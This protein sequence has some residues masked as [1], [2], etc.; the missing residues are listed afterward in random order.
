MYT[1]CAALD[2]ILA[3]A[4]YQRGRIL[5]KDDWHLANRSFRPEYLSQHEPGTTP[6]QRTAQPIIFFL[7]NTLSLKLR[8]RH[9]Q[10]AEFANPCM[11]KSRIS[12]HQA[13][14]QIYPLFGI[15]SAIGFWYKTHAEAETNLTIFSEN[16]KSAKKRYF[17]KKIVGTETEKKICESRSL[18]VNRYMLKDYELNVWQKFRTLLYVNVFW[19]KIKKAHTSTSTLIQYITCESVALSETRSYGPS[20]IPRQCWQTFFCK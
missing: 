1:F 2:S 8:F 14:F 18:K 5:L 6:P 7:G 20:P 19:R 13:K 10:W 9:I 17:C 12:R 15:L 3:E 11:R 4:W 16:F